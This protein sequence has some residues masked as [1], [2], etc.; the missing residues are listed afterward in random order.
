MTRAAAIAVA[1][2]LGFIAGICPALAGQQVYVYSVM[3][4]VYGDIGTFTDRIDRNPESTR[5]DSK[6]RI[7]VTF[8]GVVAFRQDSDTT[9][10]MH[11]DRLVSLQSVTDKDGQHLEVHGEVQ[12]DKFVVIA[13]GGSYAGP[14]AIAPSDPWVLNRTGIETVVFT[15]TGRII[16]MHVTGGG[17]DMVTV[18][19]VSVSARHFIVVGDRQQEVWLDNRHIPIMF[20]TIE[21]G[22]A[23]DF[24]LQNAPAVAE[25]AAADAW[26]AIPLVRQPSG[27]K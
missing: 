9:E 13:T 7:A 1:M 6:L 27:L 10:I 24:V 18:N 19:G 11:G 12:G 15:D 22:T 8:L 20:R 23:I 17:Y 25:G 16:K 3:H 26:K 5:I 2:S 14:A 21:N 4:P